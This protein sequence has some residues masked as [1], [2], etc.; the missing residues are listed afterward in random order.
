MLFFNG[1][2]SSPTLVGDLAPN[3]Y[4]NKNLNYR[5]TKLKRSC[6][7]LSSGLCKEIYL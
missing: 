2:A 3:E 1:K 6:E 7:F 5:K 4:E